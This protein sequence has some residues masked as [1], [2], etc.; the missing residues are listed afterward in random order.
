MVQRG[1]NTGLTGAPFAVKIGRTLYVR[2]LPRRGAVV[3][4][5]AAAAVRH[6]LLV[7]VG[8]DGALDAL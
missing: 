8:P 2:R 4:R 1:A 5:G 7:A 6:P 3:P